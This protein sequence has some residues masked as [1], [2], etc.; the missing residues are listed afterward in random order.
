MSNQV[1]YPPGNKGCM[2]EYAGLLAGLGNPGPKYAGTRHNCGFMLVDLLL[3]TAER[4]GNVAELNGKKFNSL[5]WRVEMPD[6]D[7]IWLAAK[8]QTFMNDSGRAVQPILSWFRLPSRNLV[9]AHDE[10]DIPPGALRFKFG[11]GNAGHNGLASISQ[12]LGTND[13]YR[14]RI[15]IGKPLHKSDMLNW[16]LGKPDEHDRALIARAMPLALETFLVFNNDGLAA[17][18]GFAHAAYHEIAESL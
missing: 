6:I 15:G 10:L 11:G 17:A 16:V 7:G 14:L 8:P 12:C 9:V 4:D 2:M 18:T 13:Y 5:L 3:K 1:I